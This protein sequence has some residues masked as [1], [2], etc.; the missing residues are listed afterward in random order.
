[1]AMTS[2]GR[3]SAARDREVMWMIQ[4][5]L[6]MNQMTRSSVCSTEGNKV[7]QTFA[8]IPHHPNLAL[9]T[10]KKQLLREI[11]GNY[12]VVKHAKTLKQQHL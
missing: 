4:M 1:M 5:T 3:T 8:P 12:R 11:T 7:I 10:G 6:W 9:L 2:M